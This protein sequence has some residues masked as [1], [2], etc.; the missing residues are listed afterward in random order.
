MTAQSLIKHTAELHWRDRSG[1]GHVEIHTAWSAQRAVSMA[2]KRA[3]SM[4]TTG[5]ATAYT[6][7][8]YEEVV[9]VQ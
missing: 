2:W 3:R 5:Q 1:Y 4:M 8:H 7:R 6:T 9:G